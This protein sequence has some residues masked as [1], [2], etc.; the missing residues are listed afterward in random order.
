MI[1]ICKNDLSGDAGV[2]VGPDGLQFACD[3]VLPSA[4]PVDSPKF[5]FNII[6]IFVSDQNVQSWPAQPHTQ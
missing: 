3:A 1:L 2:H 5:H 6:H 4:E